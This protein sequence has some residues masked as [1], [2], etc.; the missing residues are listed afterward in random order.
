MLDKNVVRD[1]GQASN[2]V[3]ASCINNREAEGIMLLK[4][5]LY[6]NSTVAAGS[7]LFL[8]L[9]CFYKNSEKLIECIP[10]LL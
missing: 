6:K 2:N 1:I 10:L 3:R 7:V 8:L 5:W 9:I 4:R